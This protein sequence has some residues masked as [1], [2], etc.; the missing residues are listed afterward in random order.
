MDAS[1]LADNPFVEFAT[2]LL[3]AAV[4][5][6][7]ARLLRQP[8]IVAFIVLGILA[9]PSALGVIHSEDQI[10]L[11]AEIGIAILL[12]VV[13]LKLDLSLIRTT[14]GVALF[15]GLGQ[16]IFTSLFGFII[17]LGLGFSPMASLYIAVA[18]TFSSTIIIVKL[19]SDKKEIDSLHGQIAVGFLI[20]QDIVVILVMIVL[21]ALGQDGNDGVAQI[22]IGVALKGFGLLVVTGL[23]MKFVLPRLTNYLASSQELLVLFAIAWAVVLAAISELMGFSREV[24]AF[25]AGVSLASTHYREII[26]GRL[27]SIRDFLLLFFFINLGSQLDLS[28]LGAQVWPALV[29]SV[30]VLIGNPVIVLIIMGLMGYRKRTGFLAGLTVAQISEFSLIFAALGL[31]LGHISDEVVGLITLVGLI[32]IALSTYMIIY[33]H[34]LFERLA[35]LLSIFEKANPYREAQTHQNEVRHFD[36][37]VF[38][39][40]RYGGNMVRRLSRQGLTVLG[41]DFD[42][43]AVKNYQRQGFDTQYGDVEDPDL[44]EQLPINQTRFLISSTPQLHGNLTLLKTM[45]E[46]GFEGDILLTAHSSE[47]AGALQG[48]GADQVLMPFTDAAEVIVERIRELDSNKGQ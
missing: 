42:P 25:L 35:P 46:A 30:F 45:R 32:T 31:T 47:H 40:G 37:I 17:A 34:P 29:L 18:L 14:G 1:V 19:L 4:F 21:S 27:V 24:G 48:A 8:L 5:G 3:L 10:H 39:L 13:G 7:A 6:V 38:G 11:L 33:S 26:S 20:V 2:L 28:L 44:P 36:A 9:G 16:V 15:T 23:A 12:F 22:A 41:V 43:Q